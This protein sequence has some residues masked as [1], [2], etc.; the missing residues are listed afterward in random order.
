MKSIFLIIIG[1]IVAIAFLPA[2][3][4]AQDEFEILGRTLTHDPTVCAFEPESD[5]RDAWKDLSAY[6]RDSVTDWEHKLNEHVRQRDTW[7]IPLQLV[8]LE[9]QGSA[10]D[11]D[12]TIN[13]LPKPELEE[14]E[15]E[16]AGVTYQT[17]INN[18]DIIIYYLNIELE[19][20]DYTES[21]G[22]A[23]FYY[24]VVEFDPSYADYLAPKSQL[25]TVIRHELGHALGLGH[26]ITE[27]EKRF[28][29]WVDGV[30][31]PPSVMIP[32]V[33]TKVISADITPLDIE[34]LVGIYGRD[35]FYS[36]GQA[37]SLHEDMIPDSQRVVLPD[38]I[39]NNAK[40]WSD[41]IISDKDFVSRIEFMIKNDII[42]VETTGTNQF[43]VE[44]EIPDWVKNNARWWS[45]GLI[46]T[47]EFVKGL[48]YLVGN[49]IIRV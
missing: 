37:D 35:G 48:Q 17:G 3:A 13:Y 34:K 15:F 10:T 45:D 36:E 16:V 30:E 49:G 42:E 22:Q 25:D 28:K 31:R 18:R 9:K 11:C 7:N 19:R 5:I 1:T 46:P 40:W 29:K 23:G 27:D 6:T 26:Y 32:T 39:K 8:S 41:G 2:S 4:F 47:E 24:S 14:E 43:T 21:S 44:Q 38:W 33:P 12:I 20:L